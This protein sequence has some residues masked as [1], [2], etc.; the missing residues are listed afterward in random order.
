MQAYPRAYR[1]HAHPVCDATVPQRLQSLRLGALYECWALALTFNLN[2]T[3]SWSLTGEAV[4]IRGISSRLGCSGCGFLGRH[5]RS[6]NAGG[7]T[8]SQARTRTTRSTAR[9]TSSPL[10][11]GACSRR[12]RICYKPHALISPSLLLL[13]LLLLFI[14]LDP[15]IEISHTKYIKDTRYY[16]QSSVDA[17]AKNIRI[18]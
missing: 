7:A 5:K 18:C 12:H 6:L 2:A 11:S 4:T 14:L 13:S 8:R 3:G 1:L 9:P 17:V 15:G 10:H 16:V